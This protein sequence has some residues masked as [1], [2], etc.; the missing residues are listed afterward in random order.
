[1]LCDSF[2][3]LKTAIYLLMTDA[4][5]KP[6]PGEV[7]ILLRDT[8]LM[9]LVENGRFGVSKYISRS[10]PMGYATENVQS[11]SWQFGNQV[12][13]GQAEV[14]VDILPREYGHTF[15][16]SHRASESPIKGLTFDQGR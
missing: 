6:L 1:M 5:S 12:E 4:V 14:I 2:E 9:E 10:S 3:V 8:G 13:K 7:G 15:N 16:K 11:S